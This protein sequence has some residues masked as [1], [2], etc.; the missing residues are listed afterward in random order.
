M[1]ETGSPDRQFHLASEAHEVG[2]IPPLI[3]EHVGGKFLVSLVDHRFGTSRARAQFTELDLVGEA[4]HP[5]IL[6]WCQQ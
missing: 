1:T 5:E 2:G 4:G 3:L 6:R